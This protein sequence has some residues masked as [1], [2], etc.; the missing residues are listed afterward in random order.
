MLNLIFLH[1]IPIPIFSTSSHPLAGALDNGLLPATSLPRPFPTASGWHDFLAAPF[2]NA[3]ETF[4]V[5]ASILT[6]DRQF[7][8]NIGASWRGLR[9]NRL[10]A[11]RPTFETSRDF[12]SRRCRCVSSRRCLQVSSI[13]TNGSNAQREHSYEQSGRP[14][15]VQGRLL[16]SL[17]QRKIYIYIGGHS[18]RS[19]TRP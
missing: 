2:A 9:L 4:P 1:S 7:Q 19:S 8:A 10:Y 5:K 3:C 13:M 15:D 18:K 11:K 16:E 17:C 14:Q 12:P 6:P